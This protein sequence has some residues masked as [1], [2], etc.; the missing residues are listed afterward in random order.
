MSDRS[1]TARS[2]PSLG[3]IH[4][5]AQIATYV[6]SSFF[7]VMALLSPDFARAVATVFRACIAIFLN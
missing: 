3:Q 6:L 1:P 5:K 4:H 7:V 2:R